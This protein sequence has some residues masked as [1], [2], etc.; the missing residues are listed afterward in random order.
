MNELTCPSCERP[1][2]NMR[3]AET[4]LRATTSKILIG[5]CFCGVAY[6]IR[7]LRKNVLNIST[8][9]GQKSEQLIEESKDQ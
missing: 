8:S 9:S 7:S 2:M 1:I 5:H 3:K 4:L 6:E